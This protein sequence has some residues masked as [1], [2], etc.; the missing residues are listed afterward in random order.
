MASA[1][2]EQSGHLRLGWPNQVLGLDEIQSSGRAEATAG[3]SKRLVVA[4]LRSLM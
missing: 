1:G 4:R 3:G 2:D